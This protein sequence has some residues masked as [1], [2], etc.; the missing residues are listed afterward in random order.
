MSAR[1][2]GPSAP[3]ASG[4]APRAS[5]AELISHFGHALRTP[6]NSIL[7]FAQI[8]A[9]DRSQPLSPLQKERVDQI[10][11]AGWQLLR[12][13]DEAVELARIAA[14]RASLQ[15]APVALEPLLRDLLAQ[16]GEP[17]FLGRVELEAAASG[18]AIVWADPARLKQAV[19]NLLLGAL[20]CERHGGSVQVGVRRRAEAGAVLWIRSSRQAM[21]PEQLET[22]FLPFDHPAPADLP[23]Q[24]AQVG[25]ALAQQLVELMGGR[26]QIH[27]DPA[28][29]S[30]LQVLLRGPGAQG[31]P[32]PSA[33]LG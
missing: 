18:D 27:H 21:R 8:L 2:A 1:P 20:R 7:G 22:I 15:P 17:A 16:P 28:S 24:S 9:L 19:G 26:L 14:G 6:L 11:A 31:G 32:P 3:D 29:G 33:D 23:G 10:Q 4:R 25:L 30:E 13:I 5:G 12:M